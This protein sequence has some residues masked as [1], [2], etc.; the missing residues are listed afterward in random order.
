MSGGG[1]SI[2]TVASQG[3]REG[4]VQA[5]NLPIVRDIIA[6]FEEMMN[7]HGLDI[8]EV[9]GF[10]FAYRV[11]EPERS[12]AFLEY[13]RAIIRERKKSVLGDMVSSAREIAAAINALPIGK[14]IRTRLLA[15]VEQHIE[16]LSA[17]G[18]A[19]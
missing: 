3:L 19:K 9:D 15:Q 13:C 11:A 14:D 6:G 8:G 17:S 1:I 5:E 16:L 18:G 4:T 10:W 2:Y 12:R 7:V